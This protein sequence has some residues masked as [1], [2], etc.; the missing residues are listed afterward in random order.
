MPRARIISIII[1]LILANYLVFSNLSVLL[2]KVGDEAATKLENAR[3]PRITL[4]PTVAGDTPDG[5]PAPADTP[6]PLPTMTPTATRVLT[7]TLAVSPTP[8]P[9]PTANRAAIPIYTPGAPLK[10]PFRY[11]VKQGDT[12]SGLAARFNVSAAKI[13]AANNIA[14]ADYIRIG[15]DLIIPDPAQ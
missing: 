15:Q 13:L 10:Y 5:T 4:T 12:L 9:S 3:Q 11:V 1:V 7:P 6:T 2:F 14:N 8:V